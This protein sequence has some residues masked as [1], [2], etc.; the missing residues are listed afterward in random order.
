M[1][2]PRT[3]RPF[4]LAIL[5]VLAVV[6]A[7][8]IAEAALRLMPA[9]KPQLLPGQLS[10][11]TATGEPVANL[12]E[13][14]RRGFVVMVPEHQTPRP[15]GTWVPDQTFYL[16]Y[17][18]HD[19]L[20]QDWMD[21]Q[22]R[23]AVR[24]NPFGL[25]ER[26]EI[27]PQKP[28]GEHRILCIGDSFTFGW[29]VPE[30]KGWVRMLEDDLRQDDDDVRTVNCG[31]VGALVIDE[32]QAA[33][34]HRF[35]GYDPDAVIVTVCLNDLIPCSGLF[36]QGPLPDTGLLT[37]DL[38]LRALG[39]NAMDLDPDIDWVQ[40]LLDFPKQAG[41]DGGIYTDAN[42]HDAM[43]AQGKPQQAL[44]AMKAW[45]AERKIKLMVVLW[46]FLQGLGTGRHY[47]FAKLHGMVGAEC[48]RLG[49]PFLDVL[50][51]LQSTP[52]EELWVTPAD[53]HAN[54]NAMRLVMPLLTPFVREH[55]SRQ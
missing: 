16:C 15:R 39:H 20:P 50:P 32:Y 24:I 29:G 11:Q 25:R 31:A 41:E 5:V 22:G 40:L 36:V 46:P 43:W 10:Y 13:A 42:P 45:C 6:I 52:H 48:E 23:V 51:A 1:S 30:E 28:D 55:G 3:K 17:T 33:L 14:I 18:D 9:G 2:S 4:L 12:G 49:I 26:P 37:L 7:L 21:A 8:G 27:T 44:K 53:M 35:A 19:T 47:P 54:P 38:L 34:Q